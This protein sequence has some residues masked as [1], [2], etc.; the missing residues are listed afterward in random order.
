MIAGDE[1][2]SAGAD[3]V[4]LDGA[5]GGIFQRRMLG[6]PQIVVAGEG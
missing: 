3:A 6:K 4:P 2:R 1:P 5:H